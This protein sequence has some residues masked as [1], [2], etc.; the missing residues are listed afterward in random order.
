MT[1]GRARQAPVSCSCSS[2]LT[3]AHLCFCLF[4]EGHLLDEWDELSLEGY[5]SPKGFLQNTCS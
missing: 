1:T 4:Q 2:N 3:C 5:F